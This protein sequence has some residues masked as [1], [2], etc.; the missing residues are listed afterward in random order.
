[1][2]RLAAALV[3]AA[4]P[5]AAQDRAAAFAAHLE[6]IPA[7]ILPAFSRLPE[8]DFGD[9]EA[10][11]RAIAAVQGD[12]LPV[13]ATP[14]GRAWRAYLP[15][16]PGLSQNLHLAGAWPALIGFGLQDIHSW[17][18]LLQTPERL[19]VFGLD[20]GVQPAVAQALLSTGYAKGG[21]AFPAWF[22]NAEDYGIDFDLRDPAN[23]FGGT[24]GQASRVAFLGPLL[25][26]SAAWPVI[27]A[28]FTGGPSLAERP[29]IAA[30]LAA[31][32]SLP[33]GPGLVTARLSLDPQTYAPR[34]PSL[35]GQGILPWSAGLFA[36]LSDGQ[37]DIMAIALAYATRDQAKS[38]AQAMLDQWNTTPLPTSGQTLGQMTGAALQVAVTGEGPFAAL[39]YTV[40][41]TAFDDGMIVNRVQDLLTRVWTMGELS[42]VGPDLP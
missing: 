17:T 5:L 8:I 29:D 15:A 25:L 27:D 2:F 13:Y 28:A 36:D 19:L 20:D 22:R 34:D 35:A 6:A 18:I 12:V 31:L 23:P 30:T 41:P 39:A 9:L 10:A 26:Q 3:L 14:E 40:G 32:D 11:A 21:R 37:T 33:A 4:T 38:A 1:M 24:L 7:A 42:L 16:T